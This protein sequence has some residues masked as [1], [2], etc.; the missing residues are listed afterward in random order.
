MTYLTPKE[1]KLAQIMEYT[2]RDEAHEALT[3]AGIPEDEIP[4]LLERLPKECTRCYGSGGTDEH[5]C[6]FCRKGKL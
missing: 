3:E 1:R 5:P 6:P 4:E 2:D